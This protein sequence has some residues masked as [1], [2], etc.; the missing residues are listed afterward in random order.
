VSQEYYNINEPSIAESSHLQDKPLLP[1][2]KNKST[3]TSVL[4]LLLFMIVGYFLYQSNI[5][6]V[7]MITVV[8]LIHELGHLLAMKIFNYSNLNIFFIPFFGGAATGT[9]KI[10]SQ[11]EETII[12][13]AGPLPGIIIGIILFLIQNSSDFNPWLTMFYRGFIFINLI[14]LLPIFPLDGGRM[15]STMFLRSNHILSAVFSFLSMIAIVYFA[16]TQHEYLFMIFAFFIFTGA[17]FTLQREKVKKILHNEGINL[18]TTYE[19]LSAEEYHIIRTR[20]VQKNPIYSKY[21][22]F[23]YDNT[24]KQ[25]IGLAFNISQMFVPLPKA[26]FNITGKVIIILIWILSFVVPILLEMPL[27]YKR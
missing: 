23:E 14:N 16:I 22:L 9:K 17:L 15:L 10:V 2:Q 1:I 5:K 12:L 18:N 8:I 27:P 21:D 25:E 13:L 20:M 4:S 19:Q 11:K 6:I 3:S 26:D 24:S 7:V